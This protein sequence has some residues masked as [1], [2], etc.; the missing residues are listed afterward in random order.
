VPRRT[1]SMGMPHAT[2]RFTVEQFDRMGEVGLF[3]EDDRVELLDGEVVELT[4]IGPYHAACVRRLEARLHAGAGAR[5][6]V[7]GQSPIVAGRFWE[8]QPDVCLLVPRDDFYARAHPRGTDV[9]LV[10]EV[11]DT[12]AQQ[13]RERK[14]PAYAAAGIPEAWL[15]NLPADTVEIHRDPRD[16]RYAQ[17]RAAHRGETITSLALPDLTLRVDDIL[18]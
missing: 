12:S 9:L 8:P 14:I 7:S 16:D 15:V 5:V 18:G 17:V 10:I 1:D 3:H 13:D 4:P 6:T 2:H 11:A